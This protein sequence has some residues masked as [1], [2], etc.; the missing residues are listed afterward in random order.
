MSE[1]LV[2]PTA[3]DRAREIEQNALHTLVTLAFAGKFSASPGIRDGDGRYYLP[4]IA[5][6]K[7]IVQASQVD[8]KTSM[9]E[10]F[11]CDDYSYMLNGEMSAH[12]HDA[13]E[14]RLGLCSGIV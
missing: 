13:G 14:M 10:R 7:L 9:Q 1:S 3:L 2:L 11:D 5:K 4:T 12:A 8:R 6:I